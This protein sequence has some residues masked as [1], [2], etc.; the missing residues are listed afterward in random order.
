MCLGGGSDKAQ[1]QAQQQQQQQQADIDKS[2]AG[3]NTIFDDPNR[4]AEYTQL[5]KDVT[6]YYTNDVNRQENIAARQQKFALA[7]QGLAGGSQQAYEGG[8]LSQ[9][10][11][12]ALIKA[13]DLGQSA[14]AN[15]KSSDES[16]R[17]SLIS[18]AEAGLSA[19][20][21]A[22][23]A[24]GS[25]ATNLQAGESTS[26]AAGIG[27]LFG[28]LTQY[29]QDSQNAAALRQGLIQGYGSIFAPIAAPSSGQP[30]GYDYGGP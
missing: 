19:Q 22:D 9:D 7:R 6:Q 29:T 8:Q 2:V 27:D 25:L 30:G 3:I 1:K 23:Q 4:Q 12:R 17:E 10:Y 26:R 11:Q 20:D 16:T 28:D 5:D 18:M 14:E 13:S 15:L 21:A 24:T